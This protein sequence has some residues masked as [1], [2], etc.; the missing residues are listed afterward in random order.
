MAKKRVSKAKASASKKRANKALV[1]KAL[2]DPKFRKLLEEKPTAAM[3]VK[4]LSAAQD[5]EIRLVLATVKGLNAHISAMADK[6]LCVN[7]GGCGIAM[8]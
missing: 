8:A 1:V 6:L 5:A 3:G 2:T 4:S 7:G